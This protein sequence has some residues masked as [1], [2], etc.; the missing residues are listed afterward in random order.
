MSATDPD[1]AAIP[2]HTQNEQALATEQHGGPQESGRDFVRQLLYSDGR[3]KRGKEG[4]MWK[5]P[6]HHES[7]QLK[8]GAQ[9]LPAQES[10]STQ[11]P[12]LCERTHQRTA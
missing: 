10:K 3:E 2:L 7:A 6:R 5:A 9:F 11:K 8:Q 1:L 12:S 4:T